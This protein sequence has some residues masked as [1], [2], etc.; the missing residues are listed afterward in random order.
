LS[1]KDREQFNELIDAVLASLEG[2]NPWRAGDPEPTYEIDRDALLKLLSI[3]IR[4]GAS[5][6]T[7]RLAFG[8][9]AWVA[10]ELRRAG[11]PEDE[12][13]PRAVQP[14]VLPAPLSP[15]LARR[16]VQ[17]NAG[18]RSAIESGGSASAVV[19]GAH[20][21]KQVDVLMARWDRGPELIVSTKT[22]DR[23]FGKNLKNRFEEF[24]G[25]ARNLRRRYPL[26]A[27]GVV[28]V[29][30]STIEHEPDQLAFL[31][32]MLT[33]LAEPDLYDATCLVALEYSELDHGSWP[34][35]SAVAHES[36]QSALLGTLPCADLRDDLIPDVLSPARTLA[37]L[38]GAVLARTP[39]A[40]HQ[41]ARERHHLPPE[42]SEL[43]DLQED[44][45][46]LP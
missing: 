33:Q 5:T 4:Q 45:H 27:I 30:R 17:S 20:Y 34:E 43:S 25:D 44:V 38:I 18:L 32:D 36:D 11:F 40:F 28:Y 21:P 35:P 6:Q 42:L 3:A 23:S 29:V 10:Y 37:T 15:L 2:G 31:I 19:L 39:V 16:D 26:A 7:A 13:W 46:D 1:S 24:V 8:V 9:D 12:V 22:M 14:R 41:P